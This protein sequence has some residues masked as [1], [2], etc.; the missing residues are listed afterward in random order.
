M[1]KDNKKKKK[2]DPAKF[3]AWIMLFVMLGSVII[4][5]LAYALG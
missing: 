5:T 2:F 4:T 1:K 3:M